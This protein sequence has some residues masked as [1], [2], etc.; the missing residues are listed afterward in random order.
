MGQRLIKWV[1]DPPVLE[2][3]G[4]TPYNWRYENARSIAVHNYTSRTIE[5]YDIV[6]LPNG[7]RVQKPNGLSQRYEWPAAHPTF[8][9]PVKA[10]DAAIILGRQPH[11]FVD[12]TDIPER[13]WPT[14]TNKPIYKDKKEQRQPKPQLPSRFFVPGRP[15]IEVMQNERRPTRF[16]PTRR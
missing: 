15:E 7:A 14:V 8:V 11:E 4:W 12:V 10:E 2:M 9:I 5:P 6:R 16:D 1:G 3:N 13:M